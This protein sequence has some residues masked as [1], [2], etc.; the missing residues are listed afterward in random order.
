[1]PE[2]EED[3]EVEE[4]ESGAAGRLNVL[5]SAFNFMIR[6]V[7]YIQILNL[8]YNAPLDVTP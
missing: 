1:M 2:D 6:V 4:D 3:E 5:L 7:F 8:K